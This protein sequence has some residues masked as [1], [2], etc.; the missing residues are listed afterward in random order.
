MHNI[1]RYMLNFSNARK[2]PFKSNNCFDIKVCI[3]VNFPFLRF[4][5]TVSASFRSAVTRTVLY[6]IYCLFFVRRDGEV[7]TKGLKG[8]FMTLKLSAIL[9][10]SVVVAGGAFHSLHHPCWVLLQRKL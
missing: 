4:E 5:V 3:W 7:N 2:C 1:I 10:I 6:D 9:G 8:H